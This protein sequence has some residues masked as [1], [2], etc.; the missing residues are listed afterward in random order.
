MII[1][2]ESFHAFG[3]K[4]GSPIRVRPLPGQRFSTSMRVECSKT[5]RNAFPVGQR[6]CIQVQV[7][8]MLGGPDHL[9]S[10]YRDSWHPVTD[11]EVARYIVKNFGI[12]D[13]A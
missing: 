6:F 12:S 13:K 7:K 3:E 9:Y 1:V 2:V 10:N 4:S 8:S 5:M 11:Q